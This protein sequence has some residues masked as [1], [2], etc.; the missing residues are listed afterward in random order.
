M[1]AFGT[2]GLSLINI[3]LAL[4]YLTYSAVW[5]LFL[6]PVKHCANCYYKVKAPPKLDEKTGKTIAELMPLNEWKESHLQK[7]VACGKKWFWHS[8]ILWLVPII[9]IGISVLFDF[10]PLALIYLIGFIGTLAGTLGFVRFKVCPNCAFMEE[11][12]AAF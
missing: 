4:A 5:N 9:L 1:V 2:I 7:H 3:W 10:S 11:C 6:W 12:H 8:Y